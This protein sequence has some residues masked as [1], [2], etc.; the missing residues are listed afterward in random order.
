MS[1]VFWLLL[2]VLVQK[3]YDLQLI[4]INREYCAPFKILKIFMKV[5]VVIFGNGLFR[6]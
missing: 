2:P 3:F 4:H 1:I 5:G 6:I